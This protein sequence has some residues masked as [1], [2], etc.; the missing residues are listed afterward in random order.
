MK[1]IAAAADFS[2]WSHYALE[3]AAQLA[4]AHSAELDVLHV[5]SHGRWPQGNSVL[6]QYLGGADSISVDEDRVRLVQATAGIARRFKVKPECHV[7]PGRPAEE[8]ASF[9]AA[10]EADVVIVGTRGQGRLRPQAIGGTA[11]KVLWQSLVPVLLVRQPADDVYRRIVV[12]TDLGERSRHVCRTALDWFPKASVT[13]LHAF[14]AENETMLQLMGVP[15]DVQRSYLVDSATAEAEAFEAFAAGV[16][17]G[18][19]RKVARVFAHS[20]PMPAILKAATEL[21]ADLVVLG[22]HSG[23]RWEERV[24]GSVVQ[25][26]LQQ[27]KTDVLVVA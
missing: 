18:S 27:L 17:A 22:K 13:L 15:P 23:A 25:N 21:K 10:R 12:A 9:I 11:L 6:S 14:R 16:C 4:R 20:H 3:R 7:L 26:L 24:L 2:P 1:R 5:P 8:I 19:N